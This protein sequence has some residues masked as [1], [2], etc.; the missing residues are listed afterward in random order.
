MF[1]HSR[2]NASHKNCAGFSRGMELKPSMS[3]NLGWS[4][5]GTQENDKLIQVWRNTIIF[6]V[7][8]EGALFKLSGSPKTCKHISSEIDTSKTSIL[9]FLV[10]PAIWGCY[11][12]CAF[13]FWYIKPHKRSRC[14]SCHAFKTNASFDSPPTFHMPWF[15]QPLPITPAG[16]VETL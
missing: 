12:N 9:V 16:I 14:R 6:W 1:L 5:A 7:S 15:F 11:Q 8:F 4:T 3:W 10:L 2:N 13:E